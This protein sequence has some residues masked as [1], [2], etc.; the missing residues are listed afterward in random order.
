MLFIIFIDFVCLFPCRYKSEIT[1]KFRP[2][3]KLLWYKSLTLSKEGIVKWA[4]DGNLIC[5]CEIR[6]QKKAMICF[7]TIYLQLTVL[8]ISLPLFVLLSSVLLSF[9]L[10]YSKTPSYTCLQFYF[11]KIIY[12]KSKGNEVGLIKNIWSNKL[13][14]WVH[15]GLGF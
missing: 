14:K 7:S 11:L 6:I 12:V 10:E 3:L 15:V 1:S 4:S 13:V 8:T 9:F 2:L 5:L